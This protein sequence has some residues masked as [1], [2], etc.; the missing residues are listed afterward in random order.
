MLSTVDL[1][2]LATCWLAQVTNTTFSTAGIE[3]RATGSNGAR[4]IRSNA[5][6]VLMNRTGSNGKVIGIYKDGSEAGAIAVKADTSNNYMIIGKG[7]SSQKIAI[8]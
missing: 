6:P 2:R 1:I 8:C 5:E 4:F 3:L 7:G